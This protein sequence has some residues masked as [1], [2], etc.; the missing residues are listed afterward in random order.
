[1]VRGKIM[2]NKTLMRL[3]RLPKKKGSKIEIKHLEAVKETFQITLANRFNALMEEPPFIEKFNE[4]IKETAEGICEK[5]VET[6][7]VEVDQEIKQL[8]AKRKELRCKENKTTAEK[9]EYTEINKSVKKKRRAKARQRRKDLVISVLE[10]KRGPKQTH[11]NGNKKKISYMKDKEGKTQTDRETILQI[12]KDFYEKL[13]ETASP[14]PQNT[15]NSSQDKEELPSFEEQEVTKSLNEMSK[16]KAP[17]PDEITSEIIRIGGAPAIS[18][19]TKALNQILTLKEIPPSWNE[20][21]IIILYKKGVPGDIANYRPISLLSH[22]Y[23]IFT[24]LIQKRMERIL[25]ENQPRDQASFRKAFSTTD[26]MHTLNVV[27]FAERQ[28]WKW[29]GHVARMSDN[30]WTKRATEWHPRIGKRSR[31]RQ[32]LRWSDSISNVKG[33]LWHREAGDKN[34]WR[35][36]AEGYILQW[37]DEAS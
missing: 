3:K 18:Y 34:R 7:H 33:R 1:M 25:D 35:L 6:N 4:V 14:V 12:C 17:G 32:P 8:E 5:Q 22:S 9:I 2:L 16:N 26:H 24:R 28:K 21:K 10:Q 36:D 37:M 19:L 27:L 11:K 31:G 15:R 23:K 29:A 20:A 30:R 13:Y